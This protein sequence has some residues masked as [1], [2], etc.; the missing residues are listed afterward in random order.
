MNEQERII[1][2]RASGKEPSLS[3]GYTLIELAVIIAIVIVVSVAALAAIRSVRKADISTTATRLAVS[4]R[5]LYDLSVLNNRPYR[6]VVDI[7][8]KAYWAELA[9]KG[10]C[11]TTALLP[12]ENE[13]KYDSKPMEVGGEEGEL[14]GLGKENLLRRTTLP[15][16]ITFQGLMTTHQDEP[17]EDGRGE[18]YFFPSGYVERAFI[19]LRQDEDVYTVETLP[20]RG[21]A[22]VRH[23]E[24]D[25]RELLD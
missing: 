12:S 8:G 23:E 13:Q 1:R 16:G 5:Y 3:A 18:I 9:D 15:K 24:L 6:L 17:I 25:P 14:G 2:R 7:A 19:Y 11:G 22:I 20:L 10:G 21:T 4:I